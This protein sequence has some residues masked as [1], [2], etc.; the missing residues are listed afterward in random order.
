[1]HA[2]PRDLTP[3]GRVVRFGDRIAVRC[4][5]HALVVRGPQCREIPAVDPLVSRF[6]DQHVTMTDT[7]VLALYL[8]PEPAPP[9]V[10]S[11]DLATGE[12]QWDVALP[13]GWRFTGTGLRATGDL[14]LVTS[15]TAV[16]ALA[17]ADGRVRYVLGLP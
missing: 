12:R 3:S 5:V 6:D 7:A 13:V 16:W 8:P 15:W 10:T 1:M 4:V 2:R 11:I 14:V 17:L 9:R